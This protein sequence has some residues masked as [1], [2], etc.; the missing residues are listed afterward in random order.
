MSQEH[1]GQPWDCTAGSGRGKRT[2]QTGLLS[3]WPLRLVHLH[4]CCGSKLGKQGCASSHLDPM[5]LGDLTD[6]TLLLS[7]LL[8]RNP[9]LTVSARSFYKEILSPFKTKLQQHQSLPSAV[10][11]P[12]TRLWVTPHGPGGWAWSFAQRGHQVPARSQL[13][14]LQQRSMTQSAM[15]CFEAFQLQTDF[16]LW[17]ASNLRSKTRSGTQKE[18]CQ[19]RGKRRDHASGCWKPPAQ[20]SAWWSAC[21]SANRPQQGCNCKCNHCDVCFVFKSSF[22][23]GNLYFIELRG[24]SC[25]YKAQFLIIRRTPKSVQKICNMNISQDCEVGFKPSP[26]RQHLHDPRKSINWSRF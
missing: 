4:H 16:P 1:C 24:K 23:E 25:C 2:E 5:Y 3:L 14:A 13:A 10:D 11:M 6:K 20:P 7:L 19:L 12:Q 8:K 21:Y 26:A 15:V 9:F 22:W 18:R 17:V